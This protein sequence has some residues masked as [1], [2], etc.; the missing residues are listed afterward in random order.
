MVKRPY[1]N[2][3]YY[4][5]IFVE[6]LHI[7]FWHYSGSE[8]DFFRRYQNLYYCFSFLGISHSTISVAFISIITTSIV[9]VVLISISTLVLGAY[10]IKKWSKFIAT[11]III[12]PTI[13]WNA[14]CCFIIVY[15]AYLV[16]IHLEFIPVNSKK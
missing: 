13:H 12:I 14:V 3:N 1:W 16:F 5:S 6:K 7:L 15:I 2:Y 11:S 8:L 10:C 9:V 4:S